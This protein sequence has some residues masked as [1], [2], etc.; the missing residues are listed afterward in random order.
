MRNKLVCRAHDL[1]AEIEEQRQRLH[2]IIARSREV[3][4]GTCP[5]SFLGRKTQEPFPEEKDQ[6]QPHNRINRV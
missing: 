6:T 4:V 1:P 5:D 2:E 3:L